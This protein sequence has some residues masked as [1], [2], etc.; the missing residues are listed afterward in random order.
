MSEKF[1]IPG[2]LE[3]HNEA[4]IFLKISIKFLNFSCDFFIQIEFANM[5]MCAILHLQFANSNL[6]IF[7]FNLIVK[8]LRPD[9][10]SHLW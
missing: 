8:C 2:L 4:K 1:R 9:S 3:M 6:K 5:N 10:H 7:Q